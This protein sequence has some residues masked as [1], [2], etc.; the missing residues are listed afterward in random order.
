M[1]NKKVNAVKKSNAP[2]RPAS[3]G[4]IRSHIKQAKIAFNNLMAAP[5]W[6]YFDISCGRY[7][8]CTTCHFLYGGEEYSDSGSKI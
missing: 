8:A 1:A 2:A 6:H 5:A 3:E 7:V 4:F